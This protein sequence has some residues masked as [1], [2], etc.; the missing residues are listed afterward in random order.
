MEKNK[1][2]DTEFGQFEVSQ[3]AVITFP[4]GVYGFEQAKQYII[5]NHDDHGTIMS[6]QSIEG[7]KPQFIV[8][9]PFAILPDYTPVLSPA[10]LKRLDL[11][12]AEDP[13]AR[14]L[15]IAIIKEDLADSVVNLKSPIVIN[16]ESRAAAQVFLENSNY[17]MRYPIFENNGGA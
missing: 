11:K 10:D 16:S 12:S 15:V 13:R 9:D 4:D 1:I 17:P 5:I 14:F 3:D 7:E 6:L 8:L 2:I